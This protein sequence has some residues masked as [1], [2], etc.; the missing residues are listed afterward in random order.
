MASILIE[1]ELLFSEYLLLA[2][3]EFSSNPNALLS[4]IICYKSVLFINTQLPV[5]P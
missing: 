3:Y 4:Y 5:V 2:T 1:N